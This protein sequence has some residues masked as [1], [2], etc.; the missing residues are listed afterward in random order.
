MRTDE[1]ENSLISDDEYTSRYHG[2]MAKHI[3][4]FLSDDLSDII[5]EENG[6][7]HDLYDELINAINEYYTDE[8]QAQLAEELNEEGLY[9]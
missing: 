2:L 3:D 4:I 7:N 1:N 8:V 5:T 6:F 9:Y